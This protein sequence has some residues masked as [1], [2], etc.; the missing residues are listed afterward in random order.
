MLDTEGCDR[1]AD[2]REA[3]LLLF[4]GLLWGMPYALTK[5]SLTTIP[6][7]SLVA[8]R[9]GLAAATL[10]LFVILR[11]RRVSIRREFVRGI[12]LQGAFT[13]I[14]P[15]TLITLGQQTVDSALAA[16]LN[17]A[18]PLFVCLASMV[19]IGKERRC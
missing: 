5:V 15:Y 3:C 19:W 9:V 14:I 18:T 7:V 4:L 1:K 16:I 17:S 13:C 2:W 11:R 8:A 6:P 10:W 12:A